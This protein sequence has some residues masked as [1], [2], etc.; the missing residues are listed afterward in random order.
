MSLCTMPASGLTT[1]VAEEVP[2]PPPEYDDEDEPVHGDIDDGGIEANHTT[3]T[4]APAPVTPPVTPPRA[5][6]PHTPPAPPATTTSADS[7]F[8]PTFVP[9]APVVDASSA[10]MHMTAPVQLPGG[11]LIMPAS[12]PSTYGPVAVVIRPGFAPVPIMPLNMLYSGVP[13]QAP[14]APY[15]IFRPNAPAPSAVPAAHTT[16]AHVPARPVTPPFPSPPHHSQ[17]PARPATPP[18]PPPVSAKPPVRP[19]T[20]PFPPPVTSVACARPVTPPFPQS[21]QQAFLSFSQR[22]ATSPKPDAQDTRAP[23]TRPR[24]PPMPPPAHADDGRMD[25]S[26]SES[27]SDQHEHS[28]KADIRAHQP[29]AANVT[30]GGVVT[31][32][33][34]D[35]VTVDDYLIIID[36][37]LPHATE[38]ELMQLFEQFSPLSADMTTSGRWRVAFATAH[39]RNRAHKLKNYIRFQGIQLFLM[40]KQEQRRIPSSQ[41]SDRRLAALRADKAHAV[42]SE[43]VVQLLDAVEKTLQ[44][45]KVD[46]VVSDVVERWRKQQQQSLPDIATAPLP[47]FKRVKLESTLAAVRR[48]DSASEHAAAHVP[49]YDMQSESS[50]SSDD[51]PSDDDHEDVDDKDQSGIRK[52][53]SRD[54]LDTQP[55]ATIDVDDYAVMKDAG[56]PRARHAVKRKAS[57]AQ[58]DQPDDLVDDTGQMRCN[59]LAWTAH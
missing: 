17:P 53:H 34:S 29:K 37:N 16:T 27:D 22:R 20:P 13:M 4:R 1:C 38:P 8:K 5:P 21:V 33:A 6:S 9:I 43:L 50:D 54:S 56:T 32:A 14:T 39:D 41:M 49:R 26:E 51:S 31:E 23:I 47:V 44:R 42:M 12:Q 28:S 15:Y 30:D 3:T 25:I 46:P 19:V 40:V 2:P 55:T 48:R 59:E 36:N 57:I 10:P 7:K 52:V 11:A 58:L 45:T 24:T 18:F 35:L